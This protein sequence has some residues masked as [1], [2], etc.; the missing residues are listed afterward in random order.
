MYQSGRED[1]SNGADS[2][3]MTSCATQRR[4]IGNSVMPLCVTTT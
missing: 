4:R 1:V 3:S 2:A